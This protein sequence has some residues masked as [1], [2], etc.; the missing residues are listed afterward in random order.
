MLVLVKAMDESE[1]QQS[2]ELY[3]VQVTR[4]RC[5]GLVVE[6]SFSNRL[7]AALSYHCIRQVNRLMLSLFYHTADRLGLVQ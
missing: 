4:E 2:L 6:L 3:R 5:I 7:T 1:L